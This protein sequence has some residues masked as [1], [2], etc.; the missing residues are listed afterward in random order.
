MLPVA[1]EI[2]TIPVAG[3]SATTLT[4]VATL[5]IAVFAVLAESAT[6]LAVTVEILTIP[7]AA[8]PL[9]EAFTVTLATPVAVRPPLSIAARLESLAA[10]GS[11]TTRSE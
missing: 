2:L 8:R 1:V 4:V 11:G 3:I 9:V 10:A 5:A 6:T 7:V